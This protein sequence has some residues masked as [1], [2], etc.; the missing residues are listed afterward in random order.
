VRDWDRDRWSVE[1]ES[2][3]LLSRPQ[4]T[5][6]TNKPYARICA[7]GLCSKVTL[8]YLR[9]SDLR[10]VSF[11]SG[12]GQAGCTFHHVAVF[13][14]ETHVIIVN[15]DPGGATQDMNNNV[16]DFDSLM[17]GMTRERSTRVGLSFDEF[18]C[19]ACASGSP[20]GA[21]FKQ[22][23]LILFVTVEVTGFL[24]LVRLSS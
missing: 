5:G 16:P 17:F 19:Y 12:T 11:Q 8:I 22:K 3:A 18:K 9:A 7:P 2:K 10:S 14:L 1:S 13:G 6:V 24:W 15:R 23:I 20:L 21:S 4:C